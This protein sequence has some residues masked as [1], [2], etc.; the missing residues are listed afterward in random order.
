VIKILGVLLLAV[1]GI[2]R[3]DAQAVATAGTA[4]EHA[5]RAHAFL[6]EKKPVEAAREFAAVLAADP[7]N[8]DAQ[9][10]L[11]V[12][13]FFQQ[14]FAEDP[15]LGVGGAPFREGS[16]QYDYRFTN[17]ENVWGGCQLF[18][19]KCFED[20]G[21]YAPIKGGCID[22]VAVVTSRMHGWKTQT[23]PEK[24]C[25]HHRVMGTA[26]QS[27]LKARFRMGVKDY[28][29]GNHPIW[30]LFRSF[31]QMTKP[32]VVMGGCALA[33][34]YTWSMLKRVERPVSR[35]LVKFS[36]HEQWRRLKKLFGAKTTPR[37]NGPGVSPKAAAG[38][39]QRT[40]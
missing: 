9:A 3:C 13:L 27:V 17:V 10:N 36:R 31:Y 35:D 25:I 38:M 1:G 11:G 16:Q 23:F 22:H 29:V 28:S 20:I 2:A 8:L 21:G 30:E 4:Q 5:Q 39:E 32:P 12:L 6:N 26:Q 34:G 19:R 24:V 40:P 14:K 7:N 37:F 33:L 15:E 18:R